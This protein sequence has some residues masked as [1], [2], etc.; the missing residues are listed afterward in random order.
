LNVSLWR[1]SSHPV[2][3]SLSFEVTVT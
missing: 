3:S 1:Y 2:K